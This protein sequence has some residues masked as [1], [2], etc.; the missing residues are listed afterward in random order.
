MYRTSCTFNQC[1]DP[2]PHFGRPPGSGFAR[3]MQEKSV[4]KT[5]L[6]EYISKVESLIS[7]DLPIIS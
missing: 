7:G 3:R 1:F 6:E 2:D 4:P 5:E